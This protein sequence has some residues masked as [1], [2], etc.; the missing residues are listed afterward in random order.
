MAYYTNCITSSIIQVVDGQMSNKMSVGVQLSI[1][2]SEP[3]EWDLVKAYSL[4]M[5]KLGYHSLWL[6]DHLFGSRLECWTVLSALS[7]VT[8]SI[9]LGTLVLCN[10]FRNPA[11]L[12]KMAAS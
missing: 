9:R 4:K 1:R 12:A 10:S 2:L 11:L 7:S 5:E 3:K 6:G 8:Q